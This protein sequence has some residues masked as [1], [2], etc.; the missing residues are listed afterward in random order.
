MVSF[1]PWFL[2]TVSQAFAWFLINILRFH[3]FGSTGFSLLD[4]GGGLEA[5]RREP[6]PD[7]GGG[8]GGVVQVEFIE[9]I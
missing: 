4:G 6:G 3:K 8:Q 1:S 5:R 9:F 2:P 7:Q